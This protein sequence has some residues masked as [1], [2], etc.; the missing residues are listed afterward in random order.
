MD[1][2]RTASEGLPV[3]V[4]VPGASG[5][6]PDAAAL[7]ALLDVTSPDADKALKVGASGLCSMVLRRICT[8]SL[9][10]IWIAVRRLFTSQA[11][12]RPGPPSSS[13]PNLLSPRHFRHKVAHFVFVC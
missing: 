3:E 8:T 11:G 12:D 6:A 1:L 13:N 9:A 5:Q 4:R 2:R 10:R 7:A